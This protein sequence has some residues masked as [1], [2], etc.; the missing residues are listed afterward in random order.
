MKMTAVWDI[1]LCILVEVDRRFTG[2]YCLHRYGDDHRPDDGG[3]DAPLK[4]RSTSTRLHD[5][6]FQNAV[7]LKYSLDL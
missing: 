1:A 6:I 3:S 5:S 2:A 4:R 7:I